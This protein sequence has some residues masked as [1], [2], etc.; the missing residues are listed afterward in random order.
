[1]TLCCLAGII[2]SFAMSACDFRE[3]EAQTAAN[4]KEDKTME[5]TQSVTTTQR[6]IPPIDAVTP[7]QIET[8]T[9]ALG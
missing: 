9:F 8:A 3:V 6:S 1:M 2:V 4:P 5:S 7:S